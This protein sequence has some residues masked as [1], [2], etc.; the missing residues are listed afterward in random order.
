MDRDEFNDL[1]KERQ[2]T[3]M[4]IEKGV[5]ESPKAHADEEVI[6]AKEKVLPTSLARSKMA[7]VSNLILLVQD[8]DF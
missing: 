1:L 7:G 5:T 6:R 4:P 3:L 2:T 8:R